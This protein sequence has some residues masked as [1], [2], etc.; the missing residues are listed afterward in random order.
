MPFTAKCMLAT[1][2]VMDVWRTPRKDSSEVLVVHLP[3][4]S[5]GNSFD[6]RVIHGRFPQTQSPLL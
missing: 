6:D 1:E 2:T 3:D 4:K 5:V